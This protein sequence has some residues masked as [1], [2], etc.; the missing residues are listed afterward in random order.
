MYEIKESFKEFLILTPFAQIGLFS[1]ELREFSLRIS[2]LEMIDNFYGEYSTTL[3][4]VRISIA[5]KRKQS[6]TKILADV[7]GT[8]CLSQKWFTIIQGSRLSCFSEG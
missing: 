4:E 8:M 2:N 7:L 5:S 3:L 6:R 1:D